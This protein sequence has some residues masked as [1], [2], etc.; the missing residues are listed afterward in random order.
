[1]KT[2][3][4]KIESGRQYRNMMLTVREAETENTEEIEERK[5]VEGYAT[6]FDNPYLLYSVDDF[7]IYEQVN[8]N[9]FNDTDM[10]DVIFQ[11]N[12]EGRVFARTRNN[13]LTLESDSHGLKVTADL[14]GTEEGRNLYDEIKGGYTDRM[15]FG[16][17]VTEDSISEPIEVEGRQRIT[18]TITR[19]GK[20]FDVSAVSIPA[21]DYTEISARSFGDGV[22]AEVK[23]R[24][25][26]REE[27]AEE[28]KSMDIDELETRK[29]E[30]TDRAETEMIEERIAEIE[31]EVEAKNEKRTMIANGDIDA[32]V[33]QK[34]EKREMEN[35]ITI[36]SPEYR[37]AFFEMVAGKKTAD[38]VRAVLTSPLSV[39][40]NGTD[41]GS[42]LLLPKTFDEKIWDN[43]HTAHP[44]LADIATYQT[45]IVMEVTKHTAIGTRVSG[46]K[47]AATGAGAEENTFVKVTLAGVDY[48]KY[49]E[50]T[51]AQANMSMGALEDYIADEI[52]AE[53][54]EALAKDVFARIL[55]DA[56]TGQKVTA[57]SD[58]FADVKNA[59]AKATMANNP[60]IYA[61]ATSYYNLVGAVGSDGHPVNIKAVFGCEIK[62]DDAATA[63]TV[64]DP[65]MFVLNEVT[66]VMLE[67]SKDV[68]AHRVIVSGYLRAE[69][70]L[71]KNKAASYIA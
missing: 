13:T 2:V 29:A 62:R 10:S 5:I 66:P 17:T 15:S 24:M 60:V 18:R 36:A 48:E 30:T 67:T 65:A 27:E 70:T 50:L 23:K 32:V 49:V 20:L 26:E 12:H 51:Y 39:D 43:I 34:E 19:I 58:M 68:K 7:D 61:P 41:D 53:L 47:D 22:I 4:D 54:G 31:H 28:I 59:L 71:R 14:G 33:V 63:I 35:I 69:G 6:T 57:T 11:Y 44:I 56:G 42:A 45:G 25:A 52:S 16:F 37:S 9:A 3:L 1:M 38:E 8:A 21:N 46:K 64:V 55:S 40:G